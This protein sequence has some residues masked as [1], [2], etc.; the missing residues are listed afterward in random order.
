MDAS[1]VFGC[2]FV[3]EAFFGGIFPH[4]V[5]QHLLR[6]CAVFATFGKRP[7]LARFF[8]CIYNIIFLYLKDSVGFTTIISTVTLVP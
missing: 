7:I 8:C 4:V 1:D 6:G 3:A 2:R 5:K